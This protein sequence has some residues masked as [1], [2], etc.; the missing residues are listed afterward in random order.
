MTSF[1]RIEWTHKTWNPVTGCSSISEGCRNCYARRIARNL[2]HV[3]VEKYR[4]GFRV[5]LHEKALLNPLKWKKPHI[6]FV[7]SMSDVFHEEVPFDYILRIF[8]VMNRARRHIF[9]VLTKR[10]QRLLELNPRIPWSP[11]IWMGVTVENSDNV[12]RI[13]H[14]RKTDAAIRFLSMEPLLGPVRNLDLEGIDWVIVGGESGPRARPMKKEWV[15]DVRDQC[16]EKGVAFFFKQWGGFNKK[17]NGRILDG[18]KWEQT[19]E[20]TPKT[21]QLTLFPDPPS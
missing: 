4:N 21:P 2:R 6:I 20:I 9:H 10:S 13:D 18:R 16:L 8:D 14:L 19:P 17:K 11:H 1:S 3:G 5:T 7:N 12:F 15:E